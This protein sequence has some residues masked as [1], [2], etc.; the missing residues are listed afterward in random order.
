M[1][2]QTYTT[3]WEW[4][5]ESYNEKT[6]DYEMVTKSAQVEVLVYQ[7]I[8]VDNYKETYCDLIEV[9]GD[10]V[11]DYELERI[12]EQAVDDWHRN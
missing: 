7:D 2:K 4:E 9:I 5:E 10:E 1:G 3:D 6:D 8:L 12:F 11:P